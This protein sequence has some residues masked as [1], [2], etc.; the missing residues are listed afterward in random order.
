LPIARRMLRDIHQRAKLNRYL[1]SP[2][3]P[4]RDAMFYTNS[5][6]AEAS[7]VECTDWHKLAVEGDPV[8]VSFLKG[9]DKRY[10]M[11]TNRNP[12]RRGRVVVEMQ[13]GWQALEV[14][15]LD[16]ITETPV[17]ASFHV[18]LEP[19]DGRLFRFERSVEAP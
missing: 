8:I 9:D 2:L 17:D 10:M 6:R 12:G 7:R 16:G 13:A 11:I 15:K 1:F 5:P 3:S 14:Y 4:L 19:G 18:G